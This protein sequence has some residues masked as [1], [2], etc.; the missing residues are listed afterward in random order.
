MGKLIIRQLGDG[1]PEYRTALY[2]IGADTGDMIFP[3][4]EVI[5]V[6]LIDGVN[7]HADL[8]FGDGQVIGVDIDGSAESDLLTLIKNLDGYY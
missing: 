8:Y 5:E 4:D 2:Q 3:N 7:Y 6:P 1:S